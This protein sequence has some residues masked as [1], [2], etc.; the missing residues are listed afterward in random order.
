LSVPV[1]VIASASDC[2]ESLISK[3][4]C[5]GST[6]LTHSSPKFKLVM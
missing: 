2:L 3:M 6:L 5:N 4:T 1:Q